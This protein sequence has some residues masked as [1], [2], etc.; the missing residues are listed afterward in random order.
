MGR[1]AGGGAGGVVVG[2]RLRAGRP[3]GP[4]GHTHAFDHGHGQPFAARGAPL[5]GAT[6]RYPLRHRHPLWRR[7]RLADGRQRPGPQRCA[8]SGPRVDFARPGRGERLPVRGHR[9]LWRRLAQP[10]PALPAAPRRVRAPEPPGEP[11]SIVRGAARHRAR[12]RYRPASLARAGPSAVGPRRGPFGGRRAP[13]R[14]PV[15]AA[16]AEP[17]HRGVAGPGRRCAVLPRGRRP[18]PGLGRAAA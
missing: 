4:D 16:L 9:A 7:P 13:G 5:C 3:G 18:R 17:P 12:R 2:N 8:V 1:L 14:E 6:R 11:L 10:G 15:G